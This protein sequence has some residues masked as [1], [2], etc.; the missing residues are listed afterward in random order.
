MP[1]LGDHT[2]GW[3][4]R[5][6]SYH[7][8]LPDPNCDHPLLQ[9]KVAEEEA[10]IKKEKYG[11]EDEGMKEL[12]HDDEGEDEEGENTPQGEEEAWNT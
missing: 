3:K 11:Q 6:D 5:A 2:C 1:K 7:P 10:L 8:L 4:C 12:H 9:L